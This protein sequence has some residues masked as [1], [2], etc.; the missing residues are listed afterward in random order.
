MR[1][2]LSSVESERTSSLVTT[3]QC[4][5][6]D[7]LIALAQRFWEQEEPTGPSYHS[8]QRTAVEVH[9]IRMHSRN[10]SGRYVMRLPIHDEM[11]TCHQLSLLDDR[12]HRAA[13]PREGLQRTLQGLH[14]RVSRTRTHVSGRTSSGRRRS[15][16]VLLAASRHL[17]GIGRR[18][19]DS[20]CIQ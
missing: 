12:R 18:D 20:C 9:Y 17:E 15:M 11:R 4:T 2:I 19:E 14:A 8:Q 13:L 1:L 5:P 10:P 3:L 6:L 7:K 16:S